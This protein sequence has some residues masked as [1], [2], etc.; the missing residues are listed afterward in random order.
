MNEPKT[1]EEWLDVLNKSLAKNEWHWKHQAPSWVLM[2]NDGTRLLWVT[3][4]LKR[5]IKLGHGNRN[6]LGNYGIYAP[7]DGNHFDFQR[8]DDKV[9]DR[10]VLSV[11]WHW[12]DT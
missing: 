6:W 1:C 9:K 12:R 4:V 3:C 8:M 10:L 2:I 11:A 7:V 5:Q